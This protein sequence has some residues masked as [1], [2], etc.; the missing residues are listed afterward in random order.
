[1][2]AE[3]WTRLAVQAYGEGELSLANDFFAKAEPDAGRD[4]IQAAALYRAEIAFRSDEKNG[5]VLATKILEDCVSKT[6]MNTSDVLFGKIR[7]SQARFAGMAGDWKKCDEY[8]EAV[9]SS[10]KDAESKNAAVYWKAQSQYQTEK[11]GRACKTIEANESVR[12]GDA[13]LSVL[14]AKALIK[15]GRMSDAKTIFAELAQGGGMDNATRLDYARTLLNAGSL[16]AASEQ[17]ALASGAEALYLQGLSAFNRRKWEDAAALMEKSLVD[18]PAL[19]EKYAAYAQFYCGYAQYRTGNY[20]QAYKLLTQFVEKNKIHPLRYNAMMTAARSAIQSNQP[21]KAY[22]LAEQAIYAASTDAQQND[23]VL[24][25]A[26]M[27]ADAGQYD[28]ALAVLTPYA[29][30]RNQ[31]AY[32]CKYEMARIQVLKKDYAAADSNFAALAGNKQ[33][34]TFGEEAAYRRGELHY[35]SEDYAKATTLFE[36]YIKRWNGGQ[37]YDAALYFNAESLAKIGQVD[38]AILY[39]MQVDKLRT[40]STYKY[41]ADKNLVALYQQQGDYAEALVYANKMLSLYGDQARDDGI[42][43]TIDELELLNRGGNSALA[44]KE[45]EFERQGKDSSESGRTAGTELAALYVESDATRAK[46]IALAESLL[47]KQGAPQESQYA[48]RNALL[49]A[50]QYRMNGENQKSAQMYLSAARYARAAGNDDSAARALYGA[51][52]AF[53]AAGLDGDAKAASDSLASLYPSSSFVLSAQK[54][55]NK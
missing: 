30:G 1:M 46:G 8:A 19:E 12:K 17:A 18:K 39:F 47:Q 22:M 54:I 55:V 7:A 43:K 36:E 38:R 45:R 32:Q 5:A 31:F 24:L 41:N 40:E 53:D 52:E 9:L 28:K 42:A 3:F 29:T 44:K 11:Y 14:Y 49:L 2:L 16:V 23:A 33:A 4:L 10:G 27:Y 20:A 13:A 51:V 35:S 6:K 50:Q 25:S 34:G 15:T 37:F 21:E 48:A 26:G